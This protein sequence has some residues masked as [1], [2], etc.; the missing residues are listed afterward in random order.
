MHP[1]SLIAA[2]VIALLM[3]ISIAGATPDTDWTQLLHVG[4]PLCLAGV[5]TGIYWLRRRAV[6]R[7]GLF[8]VWVNVRLGGMGKRDSETQPS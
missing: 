5:V 2:P 6:Q 1:D 8:M 4:L 7:G 3:G